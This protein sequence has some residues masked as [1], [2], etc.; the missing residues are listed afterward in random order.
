METQFLGVDP[1][2]EL[3]LNQH[4]QATATQNAELLRDSFTKDGTFI[5]TDDTEIWSIGAFIQLMMDSKSGWKMECAVRTVAAI[6]GGPA[7]VAVF[8]EL[9]AH[10]EYGPMRGSGTI[11]RC[12]DGTWRI[13]QYV[14]SF[15]VPNQV[16]GKTNILSLL[17]PPKDATRLS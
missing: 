4:L 16:V 6:R 7:D 3:P 10:K 8:Y 15:S 11:V 13:A 14:L 1:S 9:V 12:P 5:G 17:A 2:A